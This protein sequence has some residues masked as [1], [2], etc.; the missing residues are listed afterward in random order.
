MRRNL[1]IKDYFFAVSIE[2][3][4]ERD[5]RIQFITFY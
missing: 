2:T 5:R 4:P 1:N 3:R